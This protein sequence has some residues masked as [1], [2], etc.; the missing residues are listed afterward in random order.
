MGGNLARLMNVDA[1]CR[2]RPATWQTIP[3]MV[4]ARPTASATRTRSSTATL[5]STYAELVDRLRS[6]RALVASGIE[7]GDRVAIWA[8][9][10]AEWIVAVLGLFEAG[11]V[12]VPVNTRFKGA[13]AADI[14]A[15]SGAKAGDG[16][17]L[18]R[19]DY[20]ACLGAATTTAPRRRARRSTLVRLPGQRADRSRPRSTVGR[21]RAD[22]RPTSSSPRAP[23]GVPK[24]VVQ[25]HGR[26]L[27]VATDWVTM[28]GLRRGDRY[29]MVNP[30][31]HMFG[32]KAG[33]LASFL[34]GATMLPEPVFDVDRVLDRVERRAGHGAARRADA[35]PGA[36]RP[37]RQ[38]TT[39]RRLRAAVTGA[40]DIPVE[41]IRRIH[42]ELPFATIITGYGLTEAGP[43]GAPSRRRVETIATTVGAAPGFELRI[44][45]EVAHRRRAGEILLRGGSIMSGYLDDP[46]ATAAALDAD[47]WLHTG[48]LGRRR[49][50]LP[51]HR[52]PL[53]G[54]VHRRRLQRLPGRDR[55]LL[56][57]HPD[58]AQAAVIGVPDERLGEVGMAFVVLEADATSTRRRLIEWSRDQMANYKVPRAWRSSTSC[59]S[60]RPAR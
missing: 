6:A 4:A 59:R 50:R 26:T 29:L 5:R 1:S 3:A 35:L 36:P 53:E 55:E 8:P 2:D 33:I 40:A 51:A 14:L 24:G 42:D 21:G 13:E 16:H 10:S 30:Y 47:G 27:R 32:L 52:R 20:V 31:F 37:P 39:C 9:N 19:H 46:D 28:T 60:T 43:C 25:T 17:R 57:R 48:D 56:L 18:P 15:R 38:G 54:H 11:A 34:R 12:L 7:P 44:V 58:V 45:D 22:D 23:P 49:R 41:L